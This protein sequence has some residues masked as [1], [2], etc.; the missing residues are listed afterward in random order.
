MAPSLS[1]SGKGRRAHKAWCQ[2]PLQF[3][4]FGNNDHP[5]LR[6]AARYEGDPADHDDGVADRAGPQA[7]GYLI[8]ADANRRGRYGWAWGVLSLW[9][10]VIVGITSSSAGPSQDRTSRRREHH[11]ARAG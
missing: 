9:Q 3:F 10:P 1:N 5:L 2:G 7:I 6:S 11:V 8:G 4:F